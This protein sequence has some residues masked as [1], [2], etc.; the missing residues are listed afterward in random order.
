[1]S[2]P[3]PDKLPDNLPSSA[4]VGLN[5]PDAQVP[6]R[7]VDLPP[8]EQARLARHALVH[9]LLPLA[10]EDEQAR[11]TFAGRITKSIMPDA[12][13][14][15][16]GVVSKLA[17]P[18]ARFERPRPATTNRL[19]RSSTRRIVRRRATSR[20]VPYAL[21]AAVAACVTI[22]FVWQYDRA[23]APTPATSTDATIAVMAN[24]E[25]ATWATPPG[26][27]TAG[28]RLRLTSGLVELE[29]R[30]KGR[31][32]L[33]GPADLELSDPMRAVLRGGRLVLNVTPGGHGY[34]VQTPGGVFTDLGT[35]FGVIVGPD[36]SV[37]AHVI[38][39]SISARTTGSTTDVVLTQN[40]AVRLHAGR[41]EPITVDPGAFYTRL[42]P[43]LP[44]APSWI[45]W[46]MDDGSG[47]NA[48]AQVHGF[49]STNAELTLKAVRGSSPPKWTTGHRGD[50]LA[51][52]GRGGYAESGFPGIA[53]TQPRTVTCW[54]RMPRDFTSADGFAIVSWG[55]PLSPGRG[56]VWQV[57]LNPLV[58]DGPI[59]RLRVGTHGGKLVGTT[60]LRDDRWHHI[61]VVMYGGVQPDIGTH[62]MVYVDGQL[63]PV[64]RRTVQT[65]DTR[66]V[67]DGH[68]VWVGRNVTHQQDNRNSP[69]GFLRGMV[70]DLVITAGA[71][72]QDEIRT[73]MDGR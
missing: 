39:G 18:S 19:S 53:G 26:P 60:D 36:G 67:D 62:V 3:S 52:D 44:Q 46:R 29:L 7:F 13:P 5:G 69:H 35:R 34:Q 50:A 22:A 11:R 45:R 28:V 48:A 4:R 40:K 49:P 47:P 2:G 68:G 57:S 23:A 33:D 10:L 72:T 73:L 6:A 58:A 54:I 55:D 56:E 66:I 38:E 65:I 42:P 51:F 31:L 63:E 64:S 15:T 32:V 8:T 24:S 25:S 61:A 43:H 71:L 41:A 1:M 16:R 27:L 59:G 21:A 12:A 17:R 30:D 14:F 20:V 9:A 70:D 37:E